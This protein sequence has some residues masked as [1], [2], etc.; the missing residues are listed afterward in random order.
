MFTFVVCLNNKDWIPLLCVP[1]RNIEYFCCLPQL[2]RLSNFVVCPNKEGWVTFINTWTLTID[3]W[4]SFT[5][6]FIHYFAKMSRKSC[7]VIVELTSFCCCICLFSMRMASIPL[8]NNNAWDQVLRKPSYVDPLLKEGQSRLKGELWETGTRGCLAP[9]SW[10]RLAWSFGH[11][12]VI[13]ILLKLQKGS[14]DR[15]VT[16]RR[17]ATNQTGSTSTSTEKVFRLET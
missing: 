13:M 12:C 3:H 1:I 16:C 5:N 8:H 7:T 10:K 4:I 15:C 17:W 6:D 14:T 9:F 11:T 2:Q